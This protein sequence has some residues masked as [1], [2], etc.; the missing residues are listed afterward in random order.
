[1]TWR[2]GDLSAAIAP[3]AVTTAFAF[4]FGAIALWRFP[5]DQ[6]GAPGG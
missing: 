1:M 5:T 6:D 2:G 3:I 4:A